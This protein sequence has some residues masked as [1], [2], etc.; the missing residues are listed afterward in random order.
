MT[1][2]FAS[3]CDLYQYF[4][5]CVGCLIYGEEGG[6]V[7]IMK[8]EKHIEDEWGIR[9]PKLKKVVVRIRCGVGAGTPTFQLI[10][11]ASQI[12]KKTIESFFMESA[13]KESRVVL[14]EAL[15]SQDE[16]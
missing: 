2:E 10:R 6:V 1:C 4:G 13:L 3:E 14:A 16:A 9:G 5:I 7:D 15:K 12:R 11:K 8:V